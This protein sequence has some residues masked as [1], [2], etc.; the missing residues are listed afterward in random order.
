MYNEKMAGEQ[1]RENQGH[2]DVVTWMSEVE[3][4]AICNVAPE[5]IYVT[6]YT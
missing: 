5:Q 6:Q 2:G 1:D 3:A 4:G